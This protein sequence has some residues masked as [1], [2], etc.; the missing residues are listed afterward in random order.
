MMWIKFGKL[1]NHDKVNLAIIN[2]KVII[3]HLHGIIQS[4]DM[5]EHHSERE[6]VAL[7][8]IDFSSK[9]TLLSND[10]FEATDW[11]KL[12]GRIV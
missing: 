2:C 3:E 8:K 10:Y 9:L 6:D 12:F 4:A 1:R 11:M 5:Q 7:W